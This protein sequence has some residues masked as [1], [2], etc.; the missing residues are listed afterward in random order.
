M[1]LDSTSENP[2]LLAKWVPREDSAFGVQFEPLATNYFAEYITTAKT[3]ESRAKAIKKCKTQ[4]R[5]LLTTLNL[6]LHTTQIN[7]CGGTWCT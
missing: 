2:S 4:Y 5:K 1:R 3:D 6:K 7:Q